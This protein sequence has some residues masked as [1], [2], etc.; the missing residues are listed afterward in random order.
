[1]TKGIINSLIW[2]IAVLS[3]FS[4]CEQ[5]TITDVA[6]ADAF[7]KTIISQGDTLF[8]VAHSVVSYNRISAVSVKSPAGD[9]IPLPGIVDG[10]ISIYKNPTLAAGDFKKVPP[11]SGIYTYDVTFKDKTVQVLTNTLGADYLLPPLIVSLAKSSDGQTVILVW[12]PVP[13]AQLYQIR[14]TSGNNEVIPAQLYTASTAATGALEVPFPIASFSRYMPGTFTVEL[15]AL[16]FE[17]SS[18]LLLQAMGISNGT[19]TLP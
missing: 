7:I 4:A 1:M 5:A 17:S 19:I 16:L 12:N 15:D 8:G 10:G 11:L 9:S 3:C 18:L 6:T 13:G 2:G 14:V